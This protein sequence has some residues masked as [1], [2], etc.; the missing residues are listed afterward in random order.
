MQIHLPITT[1]QVHGGKPFGFS[2][3]I[4][5]VA[6]PRQWQ[7]VFLCNIIQFPVVHAEAQIPILPEMGDDQALCL[8][9]N[10]TSLHVLEHLAHIH[11]F[12]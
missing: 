5:S 10:P 8:F 4:Q 11:L 3:H 6:N 9:N 2:Q 1:F 12:C 7:T